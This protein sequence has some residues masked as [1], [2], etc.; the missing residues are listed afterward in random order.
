MRKKR[1]FW[2]GENQH[3]QFSS[4]FI[5]SSTI[6]EAKKILENYQIS[7]FRIEKKSRFID[8]SI[9]KKKITEKTITY[10]LK[11]FLSLLNSGISLIESLQILNSLEKKD[12]LLSQTIKRVIRKLHSGYPLHQCLRE[13]PKTFD[14]LCCYLIFAGEK[15]GAI[16]KFLEKIIYYR[17]KQEEIKNKLYKALS[18]PLFIFLSTLC[19][20]FGFVFFIIPQFSEIYQ[21]AHTKLP[22]FTVLVIN[23][24]EHLATF[25]LWGSTFSLIFT[26]V[27]CKIYQKNKKLPQLLDQKILEMPWMGRWIKYSLISHNTFMLGTLMESGI[28]ITDSI[29]FVSQTQ[30]NRHIKICFSRILE[31][32]KKG[33]SLYESFKHVKIFPPLVI[34]LIHVGE[35]SG[36]LE[37]SFK[38]LSHIYEKEIDNLVFKLSTF[39]EPIIMLF[40]GL[41]I[42]ILVIAM[43]LPIFQLGNVL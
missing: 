41:T 5:L 21:N 40:L 17:E 24:S 43:Y 7:I 32:I 16:E 37:A 36:T 25:S 3:M 23:F 18:Y 26:A 1:F 33:C 9:I 14:L 22:L 35:R 34:H 20:I 4:G 42:G 6:E 15:T 39:L 28:S 10:F 29:Q 12:T 8:I 13:E 38:N 27:F 19:I 30:K 2:S 31:Q 11:Q